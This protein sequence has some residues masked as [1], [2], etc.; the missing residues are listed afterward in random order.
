MAKKKK[1]RSACMTPKSVRRICDWSQLRGAQWEKERHFSKR[2]AFQHCQTNDLVRRSVLDGAWSCQW[3]KVMNRDRPT[4]PVTAYPFEHQSKLPC[5]LIFYLQS[6]QEAPNRYKQINAA[7]PIRYSQRSMFST[8]P[9]LGM[10][11]ECV[12]ALNLSTA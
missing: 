7:C 8:V 3:R 4:A 1:W 6:R 5:T 10:D 11:D 2:S 9:S 12:A